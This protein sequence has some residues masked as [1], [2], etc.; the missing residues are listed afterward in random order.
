MPLS[1]APLNE[2]LRIIKVLAK[3]KLKQHLADMGI[4]V[5]EKITLLAKAS[6]N[7]ICIVKEGRVAIDQ[8]LASKVLVD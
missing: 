2:E 8:D 6:G 1:I 3:D 7:I 4:C 5:G